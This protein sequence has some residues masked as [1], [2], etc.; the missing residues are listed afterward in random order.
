MMKKRTQEEQTRDARREEAGAVA[1]RVLRT[2]YHVLKKSHSQSELEELIV[3]Q[4]RNGLDMGNIN[5]SKKVMVTA[6]DVFADVI[7][8][9][10]TE[11]VSAQPCV[12]LLA[13][14]VTICRRT[15]DI[16]A[17]MTVVPGAPPGE[18]LQSYVIGAPVVKGHDGESLAEE[19]QGTLAAIG[20]TS[21]EKLAAIST[22]GQYHH[23]R[24]PEKLLKNIRKDDPRAPPAPVCVPA[25]WDGAHLLN[26]AEADARKDPASLWV[27]GVIE[28]ITSITKHFSV[29]KGLEE[30]LE[31]GEKIGIKVLRPNM[32]SETRFS[33]H[34]ANVIRVFIHN[35]RP[36]VA[37]LKDRLKE[38][39][40]WTGPAQQLQQARRCLEDPEF[41][42]KCVAFLDI[43]Q[44]LAK[45][46][47]GLQTTQ[48]LPWEC[49]KDHA[50]MIKSLVGMACSLDA[51]CK[52]G[53]LA[54]DD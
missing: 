17:V 36:M 29:G 53:I 4:H 31:A 40:H 54:T 32:C 47:R 12:S 27:D 30:L 8:S 46:S 3:L 1:M 52:T 26:L 9:M 24:V 44:V 16:T 35:T 37:A 11:H 34:A 23:G 15:V 20:V 22:D 2:T 6:R 50:E 41:Q 28:K 18:M 42:L 10:L 38:L 25:V 51:K 21:T 19:L 43:Y 48:R 33:P 14:K 13:D 45:G 7:K 49:R 39:D 5:H